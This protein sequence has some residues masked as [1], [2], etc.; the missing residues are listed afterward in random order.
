MSASGTPIHVTVDNFIR[1]ETDTYFAAFNREIGLGKLNH[2]REIAPVDNQPVVRMNRDTLYSSGIF[3]FAAAPVTIILPD[4]SGRFMSLLAIN[5]DHYAQ[6]VAYEPGAYTFTQADMGTRYGSIVI[7]TFVNPN[8]PED[9]KKVHALQDAIRVEQASTGTFEIP[10]WDQESLSETRNAIKALSRDG[11]DVSHAFGRKEEV[12]PTSHLIG[13]ASGWGG[14]PARDASYKGVVVPNN[15]GLTNYRL[16]LMDIPVD[17]FW[18]I[19][20][21]SADGFFVPNPQNAYSLNSVTAIPNADG[22]ITIQFGGCDATIPNC[23]PIMPGWNY[24]VR[25]YRPRQEIL[26]GTWQFPE[27]QPV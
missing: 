26:D 11:L 3:D 22:S 10:N 19:S 5:E 8:D 13:T 6:A 21:Y 20:V 7:R 17:G 15:D 27:A 16:T 14:N 4:A 25:L 9:V 12:D 18:S 24:T 2:R 23:L 1:A